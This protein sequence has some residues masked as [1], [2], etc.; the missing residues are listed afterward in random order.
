MPGPGYATAGSSIVRWGEAQGD[1]TIPSYF[2][3]IPVE[4]IGPL[5]FNSCSKITSLT[6]PYGV[7]RIERE[8]FRDCTKLQS[9]TI[10]ES[11][12]SIGAQ[13]FMR[14]SSLRTLTLPESVHSI[15]ER[16]FM[17]CTSLTTLTLP[18]G[19]QS[20][21]MC[22]FMDCTSLR[23]LTLP[24][25]V[26]GLASIYHLYSNGTFKG[27][28][29][30]TLYV[31]AAWQGTSM[32]SGTCVP[33]NCSIIYYGPQTVT[34]NANGGVCSTSTTR[35][36]VG[37]KYSPLPTATWTGHTFEGWFTASAGGSGITTDTVV[38]ANRPQT[39][40]AHWTTN[41]YAITLD[42]QGG[43]GGAES[44]TATY[45]VAMPAIDV[46]TR[47]GCVF[48][49][50]YSAKNG[51]G[52]QYYTAAGTSARAWD[53]DAA[54]TLYAQWTLNPMLELSA[55]GRSFTMAAAPGQTL[56]VTANVAWTAESDAA[57]L[58][59]NTASGSGNGTIRYDVAANTEP[60]VRTGTITV[61]GWGI[62]RTFTVTQDAPVLELSAEERSFTMA[63]A[64]G[65]TLGVTADV[66]WTAESDAAWLVLKLASGSGNGTI[67]YDVSKNTGTPRTGTITVSGGGLVRMFTVTQDG[68]E[69]GFS[70]SEDGRSFAPPGASGQELSV[71]AN[72]PWTA[73]SDAAWLVLKLA[74]GNGNGTIV[75]DVAKNTGTARAGTIT[76][77]GG[78]LVRTFTVTQDAP[79]LELS[80]EGRSCTMAAATGQT[81]GVTANVAWTA[82][83]DVAWLVL[84]SAG[85]NGSGTV[86]YD[87]AEHTG[88]EG[89]TGTITV[90]GWGI[91]RTFKVTQGESPC[92]YE[93]SD[94]KAVVTGA[95]PAEGNLVIPTSLGGCPVTSIG[96]CA[97][98][99]CTGLTGVVIPDTVTNIGYSVFWGC[100][101]LTSVT[102][103]NS[104]TAINEGMFYDCSSLAAVTIPSSVTWIGEGAFYNCSSLV[105]VTIP[106]SVT[107][108]GEN[109][110]YGC[111][112]QLY[113][114]NSIPGVL[115]VDGWAVG[116]QS[117][118]GDLDL[119]GI[120]GIAPYTFSGCTNLTS[121]TIPDG[122]T[123]IGYDAFFECR[124]LTNVVIPDCVKRIGSEAFRR[125]SALTSVVIP[126]GVSDIEDGT[127]C[128][129]SSL[130]N[131]TI[132]SS[133]RWIGEEAFADC[134]ALKVLCLPQAVNM[135][136]YHGYDFR[137]IKG[138]TE[139]ID[140]VVW[141]YAVNDNQA[142]VVFGP[143][144]GN[145]NIPSALG[146][147]PVTALGEYALGGCWPT[148]YGYGDLM[149]GS[150]EMTGVTIPDSVTSIGDYAFASCDWLASVTIPYC[151]TSMGWGVFSDC[152]N[153]KRLYAPKSWES[154]Y[155]DGEF[156]SSRA[157]VPEGCEIIYYDPIGDA[158]EIAVTLA[159]AA[160]ARV[161]EEITSVEECNAF[162]AWSQ[163]VKDS[164]GNVAGTEAVLASPH[165]WASYVLG[166]ATLLEHEPE[167]RIS[168]FATDPASATA[169]SR[170]AT[171]GTLTVRV[172]VLDGENAAA[173]DAAK[174]ASLFRAT[175][176]L[177]DWTGERLEYT[178]VPDGTE[179]DGTLVFTVRVDA[180]QAFLRLRE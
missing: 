71:A 36:E 73:E 5:A 101:G 57:W 98:E 161:S 14:C 46:P 1:I 11:V 89:R 144:S 103:P 115:L 176:N 92:S 61:T 43:T 78:G 126:D 20:I 31:P 22:A 3:G 77:S 70:L 163:G 175:A 21:G 9:V 10:P 117:P 173:V 38:T 149:E 172:Q 94:G 178:V 56:G 147:Y 159:G 146:G 68:V 128:G 107:W 132:P 35:Y 19:L 156:W 51:G 90:A 67:V 145:V 33:T 93:I 108:I 154:K 125:C 84:K 151:V 158:S 58:T 49:G 105:A 50:Y 52:T 162:R 139:T 2:S 79:M 60:E 102:M 27:S 85:G 124:S 116:S 12:Q 99:D 48:G 179:A 26:Q 152:G 130:A 23:T 95:N 24:E 72:V 17:G 16:A 83:S 155:E 120:R 4:I 174:V 25:S 109:A 63:S 40:Y 96:N 114:T 81:L 37:G 167:I 129:C 87:V 66:A 69:L 170:D 55:E 59:V 150:S 32:L 165:A 28:N 127:F 41:T 8:A 100:S 135:H 142:T 64:T 140:G 39:F 138:S 65:Q 136:K 119:A 80:S 104:L 15:P 82:K 168:G 62:T 171:S 106:S 74:S 112:S 123:S 180:G 30:R 54:V 137:V 166:A 53:L 122:V 148:P 160:D 121:V 76:V 29:L 153:L 113:D 133:V 177:L 110:F 88:T 134:Y 6:I 47:E 86:V 45:G 97:F 44:V 13:A 18:E 169:K 131:V 164:D 7:W 91:T 111:S 42:R 75:Y 141:Y 34:F 143:Q 157:C 118:S